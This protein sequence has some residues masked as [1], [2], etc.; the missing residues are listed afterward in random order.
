MNGAHAGPSG[1]HQR[2]RWWVLSA[3]LC[4][5]AVACF[6]LAQSDAASAPAAPTTGVP[7]GVSA[8]APRDVAAA[9][10]TRSDP[11][12]TP[13]HLWVPAIGVSEPLLSL[14][15][16]A[17][18]TVQVPVPSQA[19][20]PGWFRLG[21]RPGQPGAAVILGHV[22][23]LQGPA[24]FYQLRLLRSGDQVT[25]QLRDG[26]LLTFTVRATATYSHADFPATQVYRSD[27]YPS[28]NLVTC[29]GAYDAKT[30]YQ[31]NVVVYTRLLRRAPGSSGH[32][33][34]RRG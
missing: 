34:A 30:G 20:Y 21:P 14:G 8:S 9:P 3:V 23:S 22:D 11:S 26:A 19:A 17:D 24:V 5:I 1:T 31:A 6:L 18:H 29:G 4:V 15:L 7:A 13:V 10:P 27:G 33:S 25:V 28:L 2:M 12:T 32:A 16:N